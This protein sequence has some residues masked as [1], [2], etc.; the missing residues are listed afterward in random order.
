[1][2][3]RQI[4]WTSANM[5]NIAPITAQYWVIWHHYLNI[6]HYWCH[7]V[8]KILEMQYLPIL[9]KYMNVYGHKP[10][11]LMVRSCIPLI[12]HF[13]GNTP[14][15]KIPWANV[16]KT[17]NRGIS[18]AGP[19]PCG[20]DFRISLVIEVYIYMYDFADLAS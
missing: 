4:G 11:I 3:Y 18:N 10:Y 14:L 2:T 9:V 13:P 17:T 19:L 8:V 15:L 20:P 5:F 12:I 7:T 6:D 16:K 1:V